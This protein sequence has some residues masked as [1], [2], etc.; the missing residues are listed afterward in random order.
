[1]GVK[2]VAGAPEGLDV[3]CSESLEG[4]IMRADG[5]GVGVPLL[6]IGES[7]PEGRVPAAK[8]LHRDSMLPPIQYTF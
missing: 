3:R 6:K 2:T 1:M 4:A 7:F 5:A 8:A